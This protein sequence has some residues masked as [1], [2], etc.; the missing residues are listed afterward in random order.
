MFRSRLGILL[1]LIITACGSQNS[2]EPDTTVQPSLRVETETVT[3]D[4]SPIAAGDTVTVS[5]DQ[6][7]EADNGHGKVRYGDLIEFEVFGGTN[8]VAPDPTTLPTSLSAVL[9]G[10]HLHVT[11][12]DPDVQLELR[13]GEPVVRTLRT[14]EPETEFVVCQSGEG[15]TCLLVVSGSV[16]WDE[17]EEEGDLEPFTETQATFAQPG[18]APLSRNCP[19]IDAYLL[20]I[21]QF[22]KG[23]DDETLPDLVERHENSVCE[24]DPSLAAPTT[25]PGETTTTEPDDDKAPAED[26]A[27]PS[28]EGMA[29]LVLDNEDI[30]TDDFE[31]NP[32]FY[33]Q[34]ERLNGSFDFRIDA[35]AVTNIDFR[36]WLV[37]AAGNEPSKWT[38]LAPDSWLARPPGD[39]ASTQATYLPDEAESPVAGIRWQA[40]ADYCRYRNKR[41]PTEIEWEL[42]AVNGALAD[43]EQ[44][45]QDWVDEPRQYEP[46]T[47]AGQ[48][49]LRGT[50]ASETPDPFFRLIVDDTP[51]GDVARARAGVRCAADEVQTGTENGSAGGDEVENDNFENTDGQ[52]PSL[53]GGGSIED[54]FIKIG[55][56]PP[57]VYHVEPH[58]EHTQ[59]VVLRRP[60]D[61]VTSGVIVTTNAFVESTEEMDAGPDAYRFGLVVGD[62]TGRLLALTIKPN[63]AAGR[64][65][66]CLGPTSDELEAADREAVAAGIDYARVVPGDEAVRHRG[67]SCRNGLAQGQLDLVDDFDILDPVGMTLS[68]GGGVANAHVAGEEVGQ[69]DIDLDPTTYGFFAEAFHMAKAHIHYEDI[70]ATTP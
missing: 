69:I 49:V 1:L 19:P 5:E 59:V 38:E 16:Q 31:R 3:L 65:D 50:T 17:G 26:T 20:W 15:A 7:V 63:T 41:L 18:L 39:T 4:G 12:L 46:S 30:G 34:R 58:A 33:R 55:Y 37:D 40:A 35:E 45:R 28:G 29:H 64:Y 70:V 44:P 67:E 24:V 47:P 22:T 6:R 52:W 2:S 66:W 23:E 27:L 36:Q 43:I 53:P 25:Q 57:S 10:G 54:D 48:R 11:V 42:A 13:L 60:T 32:Q 56:H 9:A 68:V 51:D 14:V 8:L 21:Q 61:E 62:E